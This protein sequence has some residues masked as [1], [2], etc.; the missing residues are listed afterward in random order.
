MAFEVK[1]RRTSKTGKKYNFLKIRPNPKLK[2]DLTEMAK[3]KKGRPKGSD[4]YANVVNLEQVV[5]L[6]KQGFTDK[7]FALFY[8]VSDS[9][10]EHWK[11][12][13]PDFFRVLKDAKFNCDELV[14]RSLFHRAMG[15][16]HYED[17]IDANGITPTIK[18]YPPDATSMIFWLKNRQH[19]RW[20]DR[21]EQDI[22]LRGDMK[23]DS[24]TEE[25][26]TKRAADILRRLK[27][28]GSA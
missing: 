16:E 7:Q 27:V 25:E 1:E 4:D 24:L 2:K 10:F 17:H 13:H 6:A 18:H 14:E 15:Y 8:G 20:R 23:I 26:K 22:N 11:L 5:L 19:A 28:S 3:R 12:T 9:T 21:S